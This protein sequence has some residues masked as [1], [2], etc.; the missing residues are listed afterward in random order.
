ME[1]LCQRFPLIGQKIINHVD[2][3]TLINFKDG[4]RNTNDF[5]KKERFYWIRIIKRY[6]CLTGD[7]QEVW[8]KVISKTPV[9]IVEELAVE[10]HRFYTTMSRMLEWHP[11][12][13]GAA[14]SS[15]KLCKH[16]MQKTGVVKDPMLFVQDMF[17]YRK[18]T[19]LVTAADMSNVNVFTFLLEKA[20]DK[21]PI[22]TTHFNWTLLHR[23]AKHGKSEMC[24]L[25]VEKVED[26][27]PGDIYGNTPYHIAAMDNNVE[28]CRSLMEHLLDKNPKNCVDDT[29]LHQAAYKGSLEVCRLLIETCVDK[30]HMDDALRI[31]LHEAAKHGHVEVVRLFMANLENKNLADNKGQKKQH[32]VF[33]RDDLLLYNNSSGPELWLCQTPLLS[34]IKGGYLSV[35][36]LLIEEYNADVNLSDDDGITPLHLASNLG[37]LE[38]CRFLCKYVLDKN[39][40]DKDGVK[41]PLLSAILGGH[42]NVCSLLIGE[43]NVD[44]NLPNDYGTTPLHLASELGHLEICKFLCKYVLDKNTHDSDG[45][46]PHDL[47]V[48]STS[49]T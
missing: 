5:L 24:R 42:L 7:L 6:N 11:L 28:L 21:N 35:C 49:G 36:K 31:P 26:K 1:Q 38:I 44:V 45:K 37:H 33:N 43:H 8:K 15:V 13:I 32:L 40:L 29:P 46:T 18:I 47:A 2:N 41:T 17:G 4:S 20:E 14:S 27:N 34:A 25:V 30:N 22:I 10:V 12:F 39:A 19:P 23:L 9:E 3:E 16:I 48:S